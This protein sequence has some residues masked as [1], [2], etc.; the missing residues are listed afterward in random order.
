MKMSEII[1]RLQLV[2]EGIEMEEEE[3]AKNDQ[4]I[5]GSLCTF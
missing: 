1:E 5:P 3:E 4:Q 2:D